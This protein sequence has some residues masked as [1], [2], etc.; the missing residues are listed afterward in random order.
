MAGH[1]GH[2]EA[3]SRAGRRRR[4][5]GARGRGTLAREKPPIFDMIQRGGAVVIRRVENVQQATLRPLIQTF[6]APGSRVHTD[7]YTISPLEGLGI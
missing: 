4:L 2:P 5:Q 3:V 6:I 7:E 1:K